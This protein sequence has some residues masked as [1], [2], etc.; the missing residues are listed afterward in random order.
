MAVFMFAGLELKSTRSVHRSHQ[1]FVLLC[2]AWA[3]GPL[4]MWSLLL[5]SWSC[6]VV[7]NLMLVRTEW[8][9]SWLFFFFFFFI[10]FD[11]ICK[12]FTRF[13]IMMELL[14]LVSV[15]QELS[16]L[17]YDFINLEFVLPLF[18]LGF[19]SL[20]LLVLMF[21]CCWTFCSSLSSCS[22]CFF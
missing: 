20:G 6:Q 1:V 22:I 21:S 12:V 18:V 2:W 10:L 4:K 16:C 9:S 8:M 17:I 11:L 7:D 3:W 15:Y 13:V 19:S 5:A 14:L